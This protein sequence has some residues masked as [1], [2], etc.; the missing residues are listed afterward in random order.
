MKKLKYKLM[1]TSIIPR[2]TLIEWPS[3]L[4][5][6][7]VAI[8]EN[9][10]KAATIGSNRFH[11][12]YLIYLIMTTVAEVSESSPESVTAS[13]YDGIR[14]GRAVMMNMPKPKPTVRCTKLAPAAKSIM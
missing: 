13:P 6:I 10:T 4:C 2:I 1:T 9:M 12:T 5:S 11:V 7:D 14:K 8:V 3:I